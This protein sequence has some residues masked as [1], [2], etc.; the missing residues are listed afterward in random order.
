M[1]PDSTNSAY[2]NQLSKKLIKPGTK[3][4][5]YDDNT[6]HSLQISEPSTPDY[7]NNEPTT[8]LEDIVELDEPQSTSSPYFCQTDCF[9]PQIN[10]SIIDTVNVTPD[11]YPFFS[12]TSP[13]E[14]LSS[15]AWSS[16][17]PPSNPASSTSLKFKNKLSSSGKIIGKTTNNW[18][19]NFNKGMKVTSKS[20]TKFVKFW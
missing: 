17:G 4:S 5:D 16:F 1:T 11:T 8:R 15:T 7:N 9:K 20:V 10:T 18:K 2:F 6:D 14:F 13:D 19:K 3:W 12:D